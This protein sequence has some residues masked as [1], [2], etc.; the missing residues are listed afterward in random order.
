MIQQTVDVIADAIDANLVGVLSN[1]PGPDAARLTRVGD[2]Q[3]DRHTLNEAT[4]TSVPL[5]I[6]VEQQDAATETWP[7]EAQDET[8]TLQIG[9][10]CWAYRPLLRVETKATD[11]EMVALVRAL[12]RAVSAAIRAQFG[13]SAVVERDGVQV[14]CPSSATLQEPEQYE[15]GALTVM[16]LSLTVPVL[17]H[18]ALSA[19]GV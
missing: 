8:P 17:D 12:C 5:G 2:V 3:T 15:D 9:V 13:P 11:A 6:R 1:M 18:W 4:Y 19:G 14:R 16:T 7:V 10:T